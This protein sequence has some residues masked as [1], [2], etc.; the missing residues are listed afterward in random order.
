MSNRDRSPKK[1]SAYLGI[2]LLLLASLAVGI[3]GC[4]D[5]KSGA[6]TTADRV[7]AFWTCV[8]HPEVRR[9]L[10]GRCPT[11]GKKLVEMTIGN[12]PATAQ[13][14]QTEPPSSDTAM[15]KRMWT[16]I[17]HPDI[18][19]SGSGI[20]STCG[21]PLVLLSDATLPAESE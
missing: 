1:F 19:E 3:V 2:T 21:R 20:C 7:D 10:P 18:R 6:T 4:G 15:P 16:C 11:C 12:Q 14:R 8:D 9:F 5:G 13:R 17:R